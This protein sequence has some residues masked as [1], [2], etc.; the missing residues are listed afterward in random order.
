MIIKLCRPLILLVVCISKNARARGVLERANKSLG[1]S[2]IMSDELTVCAAAYF[3]NIGKDVTTS[4]EFVM[5][6]SLELKWMSPSDSKLL[7]KH[8]LDQG[9]LTKKGDYVRTASDLSGIDLPLAF[10]PSPQLIEALHSKPAAA[11]PKKEPAPDAFHIL[12]EVAK[13]NGIETKDFVPACTKIQ[14]RLDI[15]I[16]AAALLVLRDKGVDVSDKVGMVYDS[17]SSS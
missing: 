2:G 5:I 3:R 11:P 14:K 9:V 8:L 13:E 15:D 10:R 16:A 12:M 7:L 4:E 1:D 17:I 6:T